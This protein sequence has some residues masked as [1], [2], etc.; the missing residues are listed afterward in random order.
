MEVA[1]SVLLFE[2]A[3]LQ[4]IGIIKDVVA[5]T[6]VTTSINMKL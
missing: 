2:K 1:A 5:L 6:N 4:G 3:R